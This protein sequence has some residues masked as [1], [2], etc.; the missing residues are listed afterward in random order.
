[1]ASDGSLLLSPA[2][3]LKFRCACRPRAHGCVP[4]CASLWPR[5]TLPSLC[6][7]SCLTLRR[8]RTPPVELKKQIPALLKLTNPG[9]T[10]V[11][12]KVRACGAQTT[13]SPPT[14]ALAGAHRASVV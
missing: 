6:V 7:A 4:A 5:P 12:F 3:T 2:D 9:S 1:M 10:S 14:E 13:P 8:G 11:A